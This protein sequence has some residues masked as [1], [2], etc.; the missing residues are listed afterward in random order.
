MRRSRTLERLRANK[1]VRVCALGH[2][3]P[4]YIRHAAHYGFD[5]IW[6]DL[7]HR[8]MDA[9]ELQALMA[10]SHLYDIDMMVRAGYRDSNALYR[11]LEDGASGLMLSLVST[12]EEA[13]DLVQST[14]FPPLGNRGIDA[15]GLDSDFL[16]Q[17]GEDFAEQASRETFLFAQIETVESVHNAEAIASVAGIDGLF[18]GWADLSLRIQH[19]PD[20]SWT[21]DEVAQR[22]AGA[23]RAQGKHWGAVTFDPA[24]MKKRY[25]EGARLMPCTGE[26]IALKNSLEQKG[27]ELDEVFGDG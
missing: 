24:V 8:A 2:F 22:V 3:H 5:C 23:A 6:L 13:E 12:R 19:A 11:Y 1:L 7:E 27:N 21:L 20:V 17:G 4:P 25:E 10:F 26:Y 15:A 9:R 14:K 18:I 16:I